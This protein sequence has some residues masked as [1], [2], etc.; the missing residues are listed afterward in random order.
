MKWVCRCVSVV[1]L[2][3]LVAA[4]GDDDGRQ[5][6]PDAAPPPDAYV[7]PS[8][9]LFEVPR[10]S[11]YPPSGFYALP[12]P[13]D[14]RIGDDGTADLTD[15]KVPNVLVGNYITAIDENLTGFSLNA[16]TFFRF[17]EPIDDT[18]AAMSKAGLTQAINRWLGHRVTLEFIEVTTKEST[19]TVDIRYRIAGTND[20]RTL[21]FQREGEVG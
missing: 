3:L 8:S 17:S 11:E 15:Y 6:A 1:A 5:L 18:T 21:R 19:I 7:G 2:G 14:I 20:S 10:G 9:A 12:F 16:A 4:C 13:N